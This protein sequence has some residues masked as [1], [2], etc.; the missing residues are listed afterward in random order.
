[1]LSQNVSFLLKPLQES[2]IGFEYVHNKQTQQAKGKGISCLIKVCIVSGW[3][4]G[5]V[6][7]DAMLCKEK[8]DHYFSC[9]EAI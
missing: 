4:G 7:T 6:L 1:M 3:S 5:S 9:T 8:G 2:V